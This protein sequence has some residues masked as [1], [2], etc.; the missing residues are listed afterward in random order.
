[1]SKGVVVY[2]LMCFLIFF[3]GVYYKSYLSTKQVDVVVVDKYDGLKNGTTAFFVETC[4]KND[5]KK[6]EVDT[7][8]RRDYD[9]INIGENWTIEVRNSE[10]Q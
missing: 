3:A 4:L 9:M 6:C 8:F 1:M 2:I 5:V 10:Y 7:Y